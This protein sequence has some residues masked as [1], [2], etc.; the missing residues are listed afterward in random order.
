[1]KKFAEDFKYTYQQLDNLINQYEVWLS[2]EKKYGQNLKESIFREASSKNII[3]C[4]NILERIKEGLTILKTN[5]NIQAYG[6]DISDR[7]VNQAIDSGVSKDRIIVE[8]A[9]NMS[10]EDNY[11]NYSFF[12]KF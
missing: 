7:L 4:Y 1:M 3:H 2:D 10:Y 8:D 11:F 9:T 5:K 6:C 12:L